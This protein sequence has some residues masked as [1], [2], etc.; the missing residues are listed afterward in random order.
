MKKTVYTLKFVL[1]FTTLIVQFSFGLY[2]QKK[3]AVVLNDAIDITTLQ[4]G[5]RKK[6]YSIEDITQ[7]YLDRIQ[8]V[9]KNGSQ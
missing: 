2:A 7:A 9:D 1:L 8:A 5:Y 3:A 4:E 6:T